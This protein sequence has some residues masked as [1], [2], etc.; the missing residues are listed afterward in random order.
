MPIREPW[1][2]PRPPRHLTREVRQGLAVVVARS[3]LHPAVVESDPVRHRQL[4]DSGRGSTALLSLGGSTTAAGATGT[5]RL[6]G[7]RHRADVGNSRITR[8]GESADA[9][10]AHRRTTCDRHL[11]RTRCQ[12]SLLGA[13]ATSLSAL[14]TSLSNELGDIES[15]NQPSSPVSLS[16]DD[17]GKSQ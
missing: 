2:R 17:G 8:R 9:S 4:D 1:S 14:V 3:G 7:T 13:V 10:S 15:R 5:N 12:R 16:T 6:A 11:P